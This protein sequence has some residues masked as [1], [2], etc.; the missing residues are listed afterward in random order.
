MEH[1][2]VT[3]TLKDEVGGII[4]LCNS[5]KLWSPRSKADA[6]NDIENSAHR[7]YILIKW[8]KSLYPRC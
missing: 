8:E 5:R 3:A 2:R 6:I 1:K 4:T 7:Y